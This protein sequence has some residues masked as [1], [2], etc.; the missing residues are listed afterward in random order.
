MGLRPG[1]SGI[2]LIYDSDNGG[3]NVE[4]DAAD[5]HG[6]EGSNVAYCDGHAAWVRRSQWRW[7]W[8]ITRDD[9]ATSATLPF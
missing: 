3:I 5:A 4:P 1:P 8:N 9:N 6:A 2:W 7:Q